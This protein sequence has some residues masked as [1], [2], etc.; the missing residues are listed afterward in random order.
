M[1]DIKAGKTYAYDIQPDGS[2]AGK[3]LHC[4]LGSDGMTLDEEGNLYLTGKGVHVFDK[5][6]KE[7]QVFD[8][9]EDWTANVSFGGADHQHPVHH[10]Q[11]GPLR[12]PAAG[13]GRERRQ[14]DG[15]HAR[16]R[17][18]CLRN[19][20]LPFRMIRAVEGQGS[21]SSA[22]SG[23]SRARSKSVG[24]P[25]HRRRRQPSTSPKRPGSSQRVSSPSTTRIDSNFA[26]QLFRARWGSIAKMPC[27]RS[28]DTSLM[29]G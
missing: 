8:V 2:L 22:F 20:K 12:G 1:A 24:P 28:F 14:V 4:A 18:I 16:E 17:R 23:P 25:E 19:P 3:R 7:V 26:P 21:Q 29:K 13:Q 27:G 11:Q 9:P 15:P 5:T 10:R 6:G